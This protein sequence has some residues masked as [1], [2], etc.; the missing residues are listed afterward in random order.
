MKKSFRRI[1]ESHLADLR[2]MSVLDVLDRFV[3]AAVIPHFV[4]DRDFVPIKDPATRRVYVTK[5]DGS[6]VQL[7]VTR[8]KFFNPATRHGGG[9]AINLGLALGLS[10][11]QVCRL[12]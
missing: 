10:F 4:I 12:F 7:V 2:Q 8:E 6:Q 3:K 9:G 5:P 11:V 1:D